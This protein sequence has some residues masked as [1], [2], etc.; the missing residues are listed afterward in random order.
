M[1]AKLPGVISFV[2]QHLSAGITGDQFLR[3]GDVVPLPSG[4]DESQEAAQ[5]VHAHMNLGAEPAPAAAQGLGSLSPVL[6]GAPAAQGW[7]RTTVLSMM[8]YSRSGS[9]E[10]C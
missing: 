8:T 1:L 2:G 7:A 10:K 3:L 6:G 5:A 4:Q 9:P